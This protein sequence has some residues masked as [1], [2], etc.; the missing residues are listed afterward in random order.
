MLF[1]VELGFIAWCVPLL[2]YAFEELQWRMQLWPSGHSACGEWPANGA[3][4]RRTA[5]CQRSTCSSPVTQE[6]FGA[7][8]LEHFGAMGIPVSLVSLGKMGSQGLRKSFSTTWWINLGNG[9]I[10]WCRNDG[11]AM[12][13]LFSYVCAELSVVVRCC[14]DFHMFLRDQ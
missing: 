9:Q 3:A 10:F 2:P 7:M 6:G 12:L 11:F 5:G 8:A 13:F 1:F 4:S 14:A